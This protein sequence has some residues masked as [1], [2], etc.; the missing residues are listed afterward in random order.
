LGGGKLSAQ[1]ATN[2]IPSLKAL[3]DNGR[4]S[5]QIK[6]NLTANSFFMNDMNN[7]TQLDFHFSPDDP[8]NGLYSATLQNGVILSGEQTKSLVFDG[9]T[10]TSDDDLTFIATETMGDGSIREYAFHKGDYIEFPP[11]PVIVCPYKIVCRVRNG[12]SLYFDPSIFQVTKEQAWIRVLLNFGTEN[13]YNRAYIIHGVDVVNN[14]FIFDFVGGAKC[15]ELFSGTVSITIGNL[16]CTYNNGVLVSSNCSQMEDFYSTAEC[17]ELLE[18]CQTE[19][20]TLI[21]IN[22]DRLLCKQWDDGGFLCNTTRPIYRYLGNVSIGTSSAAPG[23]I[24]T[25]T[26]GVITD[27]VFVSVCSNGG[28]CDYVFDDNYKLPKIDQVANYIDKNKHLPGMPSA[29]EIEKEGG[30]ELGDITFRQ[31]EKIEEMFLYLIE[32]EQEISRLE[33]VLCVLEWREKL[34]TF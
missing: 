10:Y 8:R 23:S 2:I 22:R 24:L 5:I 20:A 13:P 26:D 19:L 14:S 29:A 27:I 32:E 11:P 16:V 4:I 12:F 30:F 17:M 28:W 25:V 9:L 34:R 18:G 31:Q 33:M 3:N 7:K 15:E 21:S 1:T 6:N